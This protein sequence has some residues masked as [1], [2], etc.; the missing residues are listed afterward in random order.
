MMEIETER[1]RLVRF[2]QQHAPELFRL[3][4]DPDWLRFIGD[5]GIRT[6]DDAV[7]QIEERYDVHHREHGYGF[8]AV[9][10]KQTSNL[11]GLCGLIQRDTLPEIDLGYALLPEFRGRGYVQEV[12]RACLDYARDHLGRNQ[13][14]AIVNSDNQRSISVLVRLGFVYRGPYRVPGEERD[15]ALYVWQA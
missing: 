5:R 3:M 4:N 8:C 15:I 13:V 1:L 12:A 7:R 9:L 2:E 6:V 10:E 11:V 14:L